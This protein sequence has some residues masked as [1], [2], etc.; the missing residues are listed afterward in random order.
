[1]STIYLNRTY[2]KHQNSAHI[3]NKA[4]PLLYIHIPTM[5]NTIEFILVSRLTGSHNTLESPTYAH[6]TSLE[7]NNI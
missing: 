2:I 6:S 3:V 4:N 7:N 1:M 5:E